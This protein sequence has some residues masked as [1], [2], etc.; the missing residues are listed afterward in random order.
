MASTQGGFPAPSNVPMQVQ[1]QKIATDFFAYN[2]I[3]LAVAA[4]SSQTNNIQIQADSDFE[5]QK[6]TAQI[7]FDLT[8]VGTTEDVQA[9]SALITDTGTGRQLSDVAVPLSSLF[10]TA[11]LPFILPNTK[12]LAAR[13][14]LAVQLSNYAS[15]LDYARVQLS[16]IGRKIFRGFQ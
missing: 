11:Q 8:E 14:I 2:V 13:S 7:I 6:L 9:L 15:G 5:I 12:I 1:Q 3:F 16:F 4:G 10:G